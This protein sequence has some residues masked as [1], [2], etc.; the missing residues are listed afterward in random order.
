MTLH[1]HILCMKNNTYMYI[2]N[3]ASEKYKV[4]PLCSCDISKLSK[5]C[6][7]G[8]SAYNFLPRP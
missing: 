1:Y 2:N 5:T 8:I 7:F 4:V 6:D 3:A